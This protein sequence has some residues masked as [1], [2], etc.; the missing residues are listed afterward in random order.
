MD[1]AFAILT[2]PFLVALSFVLAIAN[3]FLNPGPVFF[4]QERM[5]Q[6][7]RPFVMWKFRTMTDNGTALRAADA[8]LDEDRITPLGRLLRRTK[9]DELPNILNVL[10]GDMSLVGPRPDAF[11]HATEYLVRVPHYGKR[12]TVRPGI[13]GLAQVRGGYADNPRAVQRKARYDVFYIRNRNLRLE[14]YVISSTFGVIFSG[15]GQR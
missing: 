14:M 5:G 10:K 3:P 1:L 11:A 8:P 4:R 7:G 15:F 9:L 13:T 12:F 2:F 6:D